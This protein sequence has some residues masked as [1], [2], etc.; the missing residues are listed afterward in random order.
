MEY[1]RTIEANDIRWVCDEIHLLQDDVSG[2]LC[3]ML[4]V[5]DIHRA[6]EEEEDRFVWRSEIA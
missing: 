3:M 5:W 4:V 2:H 1:R 6:K